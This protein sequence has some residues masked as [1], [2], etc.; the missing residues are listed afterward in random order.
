MRSF[1]IY[2]LNLPN[3]APKN[4]QKSSSWFDNFLQKRLRTLYCEVRHFCIQIPC[5]CRMY[6]FSAWYLPQMG[7]VPVH[8]PRWSHR[9]FKSPYVCVNPSKQL[10]VS[11]SL[12]W[13]PVVAYV[14]LTIVRLLSSHRTSEIR[15]SQLTNYE[16]SATG[17]TCCQSISH[18]R[19]TPNNGIQKKSKFNNYKNSRRKI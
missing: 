4:P 8:T 16:N 11:V 13:F 6:L 2:S 7:R 1:F 3:Y 10:Y 15:I 17:W 19:K 5:F 18:Q 14:I 9:L 12:K